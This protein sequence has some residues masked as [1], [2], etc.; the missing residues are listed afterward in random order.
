M[1]DREALE[2][3]VVLDALS[4]LNFPASKRQIVQY[5]GQAGAGKEVL[6]AV[7]A[8]PPGNYANRT[9]LARSLPTLS[10]QPKVGLRS[11]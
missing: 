8:L 1:P 10:T 7:W 9:E 11:E 5:A 3:R 6:A 2:A 4:G